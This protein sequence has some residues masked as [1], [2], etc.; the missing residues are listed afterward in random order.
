MFFLMF[1]IS[2][3]DSWTNEPQIQSKPNT[4]D[5]YSNTD[6]N[7]PASNTHIIFHVQKAHLGP[8][9]NQGRTGVGTID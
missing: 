4:Q 9:R 1:Y 7:R 3:A 6:G 2:N 5:Q 8:I